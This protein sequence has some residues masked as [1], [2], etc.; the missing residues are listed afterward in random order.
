MSV[1]GRYTSPRPKT[2]QR[3]LEQ[4]PRALHVDAEMGV[5]IRTRGRQPRAVEEP[6]DPLADAADLAA[7][8]QVALGAL[9]VE[10]LEVVQPRARPHGHP[11]AVATLEQSAGDVRPDEPGSAGDEGDAHGCILPR[12]S[13]TRR[14]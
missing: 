11:N 14:G 13:G 12:R 5:R 7:V 6:V 3:L 2:D 9:H 4:D 10:P 1:E 8:E